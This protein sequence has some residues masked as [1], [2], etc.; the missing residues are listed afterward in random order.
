MK[1]SIIKASGKITTLNHNCLIKK[2][3]LSAQSTNNFC[4]NYVF[5]SILLVLSE[6][7]L[8]EIKMPYQYLAHIR[9]VFDKE[10]G[11]CLFF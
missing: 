4:I 8:V 1:K 5:F 9:I 7:N 11:F 2:Q 3:L 10:Y 6:C